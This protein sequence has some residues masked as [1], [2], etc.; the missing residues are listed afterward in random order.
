MIEGTVEVHPTEDREKVRS[1]ILNIFPEC[2]LKL[3]GPGFKFM[4][5]SVETFTQILKDLMIRD[6]AIMV[7]ERNRE[8]DRTFFFLNKQAAFTGRVN[9]TAGDSTLGDISIVVK[10][11]AKDLVDIIRPG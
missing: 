4:T 9:F 5:S 7:L 6:T 11:G 10:E 1:S 2:E 8:S 3:N